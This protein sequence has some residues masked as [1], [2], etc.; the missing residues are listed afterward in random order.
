MFAL[1][2]FSLLPLHGPSGHEVDT[3]EGVDHGNSRD[4]HEASIDEF[5]IGPTQ[6]YGEVTSTNLQGGGGGGGT[7]THTGSEKM[8]VSS[9]NYTQVRK[10]LHHHTIIY[11]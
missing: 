2:G 10:C 3:V 5:V 1:S 11:R 8:S 9:H 6:V 7:Y 4:C